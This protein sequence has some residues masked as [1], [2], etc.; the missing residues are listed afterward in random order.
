MSSE[1]IQNLRVQFSL[2]KSEESKK[3]VE[4]MMDHTTSPWT[5][6]GPYARRFVDQLRLPRFFAG[7]RSDAKR[8]R[9]INVESKSEIKD[10][11]NF[12]ENMK[13]QV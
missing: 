1:T 8:P 13:N 11:K 3:Y 12:Q 10:L 2:N 9:M 7:I 5:P 6:G 4:S